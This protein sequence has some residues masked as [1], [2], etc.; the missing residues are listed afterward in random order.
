ME[1]ENL[2][3]NGHIDLFY[4]DEA[5]FCEQGY[6]PYGWQFQ[7][8]EV[9]LPARK[10]PS[11]H[12]IAFLSRTCKCYSRINE[13]TIGADLVHET[14]DDFSFRLKKLTVLVLDNAAIHK[15]QKIKERLAIWQRRG[16]YLFYLPPYSP[17][18]NIVEI[19]WKQIKYHWL[20]P[21]DYAERETLRLAI[22]LAM[23][24][25]GKELTI[26]FSQSQII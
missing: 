6:V 16:L 18:L 7:D 3:Q 13:R 14:L 10:S 5:A 9:A 2:A 24:A 19:L 1:F 8:E 4:G 17:H 12:C 11:M 23:N 22:Y 21:T 20:K 26:N 15:T 25:V